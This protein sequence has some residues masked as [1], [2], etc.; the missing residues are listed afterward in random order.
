MDAERNLFHAELTLTQ[1]QS[2]VYQVLINLY[3]AMGGGWINAAEKL[4]V[5]YGPPVTSLP[6][7]A[8]AS[9]Q[10]PSAWMRRITARVKASALPE[11][12]RKRTST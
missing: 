6:G 11:G 2:Q 3:K 9:Q 1:S 4:T 7:Q 10:V 5:R 12:I 8:A